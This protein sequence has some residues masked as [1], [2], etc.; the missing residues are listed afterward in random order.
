MAWLAGLMGGV[1]CVGMCGGYRWIMVNGG[2]TF[3]DGKC[4]GV[5]SGR[6][7]RNGRAA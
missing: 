3:E 2:V 7:L 5:T 4:T 6:L 1:H